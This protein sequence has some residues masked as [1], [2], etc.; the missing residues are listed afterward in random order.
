MQ[1]AHFCEIITSPLT[2]CHFSPVRCGNPMLECAA[3]ETMSPARL[4]CVLGENAS[5]GE[6][7][8]PPSAYSL[9]FETACTCCESFL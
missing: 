2:S 5:L 1:E 6:N 4:C 8:T 9:R 7:D 3:L